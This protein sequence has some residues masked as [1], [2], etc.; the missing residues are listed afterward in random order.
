MYSG[1]HS[2]LVIRYSPG[3]CSTSAFNSLQGLPVK[4]G[5]C[6]GG[7]VRE[8]S[9]TPPASLR[10]QRT[11]QGAF[12]QN[13]GQTIRPASLWK[14]GGERA[15]HSS[16]VAHSRPLFYTKPSVYLVSFFTC[17]SLYKPCIQLVFHFLN[18]SPSY[19]LVHLN[20]ST[21]IDHG[22]VMLVT[23]SPLKKLYEASGSHHDEI[24]LK[25]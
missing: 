10:I 7:G 14:R 19:Q 13:K 16:T 1:V 25:A 3:L 4:D 18:L 5:L 20:G 22:V 15:A 12:S 23:E 11:V 2:A 24:T 9:P 8:D 17:F 6:A 21:H